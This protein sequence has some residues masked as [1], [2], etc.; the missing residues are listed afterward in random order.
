VSAQNAYN[1][2]DVI[3]RKVGGATE[4][5]TLPPINLSHL[6]TLTVEGG[7]VSG[8]HILP[9]SVVI[10]ASTSEMTLP[11]GSIRVVDSAGNAIAGTEI[12][13]TPLRVPG[14]AYD[15]FEARVEV[16]DSVGTRIAYDPAK[17]FYPQGWTQAQILQAVYSAY[18]RHYEA[19]G[20]PFF[21][22]MRLTTP[23]GVKI[24]MRVSGNQSAVGITV[25]GIATAYLDQGQGLT[26]NEAP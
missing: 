6:L 10:V 13:L 21:M 3:T 15:A 14:S 18:V 24:W 2:G 20:A 12:K 1:A 26:S 5:V 7:R 16:L 11:A 22:R 4:T 9:T 8:F 23:K 19:G 25:T 17:T